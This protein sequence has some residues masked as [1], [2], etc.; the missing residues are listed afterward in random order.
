MSV[1][2]A[3][4]LK[5]AKMHAITVFILVQKYGG[6]MHMIGHVHVCTH[7]YTEHRIRTE[8]RVETQA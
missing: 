2:Q 6:H 7:V 1:A 3:Q 5:C 4:N 8:T